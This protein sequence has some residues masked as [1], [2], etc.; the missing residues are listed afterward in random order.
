MMLCRFEAFKNTVVTI[1]I[2]VRFCFPCIF[3]VILSF[4]EYFPL[5]FHPFL[6]LAFHIKWHVYY[7]CN[8]ILIVVQNPFGF[9][10]FGR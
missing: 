1:T 5:S 6:V 2:W 4:E 3:H 10:M 8:I 9:R 7:V